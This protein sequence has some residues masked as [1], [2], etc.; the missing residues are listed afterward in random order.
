MFT[1]FFSNDKKSDLNFFNTFS[2]SWLPYG[3]RLYMADWMVLKSSLKTL[4]T[5][6]ATTTSYASPYQNVNCY[7]SHHDFNQSVSIQNFVYILI[8]S[9]SVS[10]DKPWFGFVIW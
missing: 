3:S 6:G 1:G 8:H 4:Q 2:K 9:L 5:L 10:D 7:K